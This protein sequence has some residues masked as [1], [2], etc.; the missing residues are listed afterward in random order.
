MYSSLFKSLG[1]IVSSF[2]NIFP[3]VAETNWKTEWSYPTLNLSPQIPGL[4]FMLI[5][6]VNLSPYSTVFDST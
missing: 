6:T 4:S 1:K 3:L 5:V 2:S